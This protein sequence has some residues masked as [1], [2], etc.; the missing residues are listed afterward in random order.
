M[1]FIQLKN[2]KN[3]V[4]RIILIV[5]GLY[6]L[7][8]AALYFFQGAFIFQPSKLPKD[9]VYKLNYDYEE[10]LHNV[11][12]GVLINALLIKAKKPKGVIFYC[13]GNAGNLQ[14]WVTLVE[15]LVEMNYD[16]Y[17]MDYRGFGK[18]DGAVSEEAFYEDVD[19]CYQH[20]KQFWSEEDIIVYGR[21][22]GTAAATKV[23][24]LNNPRQL[25]LETPF[26]SIA[27]VAKKRFP[28]YPID[29][30]LQYQFPNN[31]YI[32]AINC[33]ISIIHGTNDFTVPFSSALKLY[34]AAPKEQT[35]FY[36][37]E[38]GGHNNLMNFE[39][40]LN[41]IAEIL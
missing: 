32:G 10:F 29:M 18:S 35:T 1:S 6:I 8:G 14:R 12:K 7:L 37:V 22:L 21:S 16:V 39:E 9:H 33:A 27:D 4:R 30:L 20:L 36:T 17:I 25:I 15:Y 41:A 11:E 40:Y 5:L 31:N 23:A 2:L 34:E 38:N 19:F 26:Y 28:M 13:H 24:S 3:K